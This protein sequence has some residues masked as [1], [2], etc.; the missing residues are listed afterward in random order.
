[1]ETRANYILIGLFTLAAILGTLAFS[2]WLAS[3]QVNKQ[4]RSYGILFE[5]ISG[6]DPSGDVVFNGISLGCVIGLQIAPSRP[7]EVVHDD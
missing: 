4:Y 7:F 2:I 5:D 6:L 1:M 3:V